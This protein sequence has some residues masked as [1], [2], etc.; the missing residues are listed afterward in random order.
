M[1][2]SLNIINSV[3]NCLVLLEIVNKYIYNMNWYDKM[4][5]VTRSSVLI[6]TT[7]RKRRH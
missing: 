4:Y 7:S 2:W 6:P 5:L 3:K 1:D